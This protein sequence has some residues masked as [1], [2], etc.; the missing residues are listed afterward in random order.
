MSRGYLARLI[1]ANA[2]RGNT[3]TQTGAAV[4][5]TSANQSDRVLLHHIE[6]LVS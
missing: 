3:C 2:Q 5:E 1:A 4:C 6:L